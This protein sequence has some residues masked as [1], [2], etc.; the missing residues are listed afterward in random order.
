MNTLTTI[1]YTLTLSHPLHEVPVD[2]YAQEIPIAEPLSPG[3][4]YIMHQEDDQD[5]LIE[6]LQQPMVVDP[7][8]VEYGTLHSDQL[9]LELQPQD[10]EQLNYYVEENPF[11]PATGTAVPLAQIPKEVIMLF[12]PVYDACIFPLYLTVLY[13]R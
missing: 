2:S 10:Q 9:L 5:T 12:L 6:Q 8:I 1:A 11:A 7:S 13:Y 4:T 3:V